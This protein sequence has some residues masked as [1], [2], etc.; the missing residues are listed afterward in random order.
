MVIVKVEQQEFLLPFKV[1][2]ASTATLS[3]TVAYL[4]LGFNYR[5]SSL[6]DCDTMAGHP[7]LC[8]WIFSFSAVPMLACV[9]WHQVPQELELSTFVVMLF[10]HCMGN[11][12]WK[13]P[14][15]DAS[16][17]R[18]KNDLVQGQY[19][20]LCTTLYIAL[21]V[22]TAMLWTACGAVKLELGRMGRR[23]DKDIWLPIVGS[24]QEGI[25]WQLNISISLII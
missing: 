2:L 10:F 4:A 16:E 20:C 9:I 25:Q 18:H 7:S 12:V 3:W 17:L 14:F 21:Q 1:L 8:H 6:V 5:H 15:R 22:L 13:F 11:R 19:H 23:L 24:N